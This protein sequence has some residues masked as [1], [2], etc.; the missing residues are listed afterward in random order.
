[1]L[2]DRKVSLSSPDTL[3]I[4]SEK[5]PVGQRELRIGPEVSAGSRVST[6]VSTCVHVCTHTPFLRTLLSS[7]SEA[8]SGGRR[9]TSQDRWPCV[10]PEPEGVP[11]ARG[12]NSSATAHCSHA[13]RAR[14]G[15]PRVWGAF[16]QGCPSPAV[17]CFLLRFSSFLAPGF[18]VYSLPP[19]GRLNT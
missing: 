7:R 18:L 5:V 3:G 13:C 15:A 19:Q 14:P 16:G 2:A 8:G 12:S 9:Q 10:T 6:S 4:P 11:R 1:M 17:P